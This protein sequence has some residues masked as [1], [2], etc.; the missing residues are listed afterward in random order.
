M[1][2]I[3]SAEIIEEVKKSTGITSI[4][5]LSKLLGCSRPSIKN[6]LEGGNMSESYALKCT[7][8]TDLDISY[9]LSSIAAE[10]AKNSG[11]KE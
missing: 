4:N 3:T 10:R 8:Y 6:W 5:G 9:V 11:D 1:P 7:R 2:V